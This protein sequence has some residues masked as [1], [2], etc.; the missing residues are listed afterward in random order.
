MIGVIGS[1]HFSNNLIQELK[2]CIDIKIVTTN[3]KDP[4]LSQKAEDCE[5]IHYIFSPLVTLGGLRTVKALK[6]MKKKIIVHW[7]GTDILNATTKFKSRFIIKRYKGLVDAH[8]THSSRM[9]KELGTIGISCR[10]LPLPNFGLYELQELSPGKK[11][12]VYLPDSAEDFFGKSI[13]DKVIDSFPDVHFMILPNSGNSYSDR[14][15]VTCMSWAKEM[16]KIYL[17]TRVFIR[18]PAH[19]GLPSSVIEALS[20]GRYV[21]YSHDFPHCER[22]D[23][24]EE[25]IMKLPKLLGSSFTNIEGSKYVHSKYDKNKLKSQLIELYRSL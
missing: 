16:E 17:D 25:V 4:Q 13:I 3:L 20:M 7:I 23:S 22:A 2:S 14:P 9:V 8:L 10:E 6:K 18:L 11:V 5:I 19:D 1:Q 24:A 12:L 15:N 21:I